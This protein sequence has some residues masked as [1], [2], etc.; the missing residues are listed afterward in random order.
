MT[1]RVDKMNIVFVCTG[2]TCR[3]P[4]AEAIFREKTKEFANNLNIIS[5]GLGSMPG[6]TAS[7]NAIRVMAERNIDIS[8]HRSRQINQYIIEEADYII[9]LALS[10]YRFLEQ[11][12]GEKLI[13]LGEGI[14][15]PYLG[16]LSVYRDCANSIENAI[17]KLLASDIFIDV[18]KFS[19]SDIDGAVKIE[20]KYFSEPWSRDAFFSQTEKKYSVSFAAHYLGKTIGYICCDDISGEVFVGTV[21]VAEEF[22]RRYVGK[23]LIDS[24]INYCL[25]NNSEMLTLEVRESNIPAINLYNSVGFVNLGRRKDF[26]SKPTEDAYIM[27]KYFNG[28]TNENTC[29]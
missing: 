29:N 23:K 5:C 12:A 21:A 17:E 13:L 6:D 27:T 19:L 28:D 7:E 14:S 18:K 20:S 16:D 9:C 22:R 15:D 1:Q 11:T 4:M 25:E 26:Y 3:S 24:V 2:N 8:S 10:H